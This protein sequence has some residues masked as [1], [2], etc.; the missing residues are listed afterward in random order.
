MTLLP[1]PVGAEDRGGE[2]QLLLRE[3]YRVIAEKSCAEAVRKNPLPATPEKILIPLVVYLVTDDMASP[4]SAFICMQSN[5]PSRSKVSVSYTAFNPNGVIPV[6]YGDNS[7]RCRPEQNEQSKPLRYPVVRDQWDNRYASCDSRFGWDEQQGV[8][9]DRICQNLLW[10]L[11]SR[12]KAPPR[13]TAPIIT[14]RSR[15]SAFNRG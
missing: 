15:R 7:E 4:R 13:P 12:P 14:S 9:H 11:A 3:H 6:F 1:A 8:W 5:Q 10:P 2:R